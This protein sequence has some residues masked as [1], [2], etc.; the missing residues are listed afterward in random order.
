LADTTE[1]SE[2]GTQQMALAVE[3]ANG[4][5]GRQPGWAAMSTLWNTGDPIQDAKK[6]QLK[7]R[8][9]AV[10]TVQQPLSAGVH[11]LQLA[12]SWQQT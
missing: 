5:R 12:M 10:P 7:V 3:D 2:A 1:S 11:D 4:T 9:R 8:T 6:E